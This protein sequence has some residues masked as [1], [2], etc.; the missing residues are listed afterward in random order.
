[1]LSHWDPPQRP[2]AYAEQALITAILNGVFPPGS[3]LPG[4]RELAARLGVTRP[5]LRETLSRL[6]CDGWLT[7]QHGKATRL[8]NFWQ[9]GGLNVLSS[10]VRYGDDLPSDFIPNLLAV[11]LVMAPAYT[12]AAV[13]HA[14]Q[15]IAACLTGSHLL[16]DTPAAY[17]EFDWQLHHTLTIHCGNPIYTL[18]LNGFAGFYQQMAERY[19]S[20]PETRRASQAFYTAL[21]TAAQHQ[22]ASEAEE[23]T[24]RTMQASL[25]LWR[26]IDK[27]D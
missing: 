16:T 24:R 20:S 15:I 13:E 12:R 17:A 19:F 18:I 9:D 10:L 25:D 3:T 22:D 14:P 6:E 7:I 4:E 2:A 23:I 26:N 8:N 11:R 27:G 5:T 21:L 1:M